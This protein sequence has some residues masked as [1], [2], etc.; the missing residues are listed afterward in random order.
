MRK[1]RLILALV[2]T[3]LG[4]LAG[5]RIW[6]AYQKAGAATRPGS[7]TGGPGGIRVVSVSTDKAR[8]GEVNEEIL[9]TGALKP[10]E[11]V[12]VNSKAT[13]RVQKLYFYVGDAVTKNDLIAELED[14]ELQQQVKRATASLAV[15]RASLSQRQ[16][17]LANSKAEVG[18]AEELLKN[19]LIPRV[20]YETRLT[21][22]QVVQAQVELARA[23]VQ[24]AQAELNELQI[25]LEQTKVYAPMNGHIARRH[26]DV[27]AL[28]NPSQ[29]LVTMVNLA[30]MVTMA[31]VP[32]REVSKLRVGNR[33]IVNVDAF[34]DRRFSGQVARI[35]PVLDAATRSAWVEVEIPNPDSGLKAE[36]F[37]RVH[38]DLASKR[39]AVVIPREALVYRGTQPG[40]YVVQQNRPVFR[41]IETGLTQGDDVE[42]IAN[43]E[44]GTP[45]VTRGASMITEGDQIRI[46]RPPGEKKT[47]QADPGSANGN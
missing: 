30:I 46:A 21:H 45:I 13:G 44:A 24:Q 29:P 37:A 25:R 3:A 35:S 38:L 27:G 19:G 9:L 39:Q 12:D 11:Q 22:F 17:E 26:V 2:L 16:A 47:A 31:N 20:D 36:M 1:K 34:G 8:S 14:D 32:E 18:R 23:Q 10:K 28:V 7:K 40:V 15:S 41:M 4:A 43:L 33:A 42:V 6:Q 5:V